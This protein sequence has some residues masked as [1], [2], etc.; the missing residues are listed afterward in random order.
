MALIFGTWLEFDLVRPHL[1][2]AT[3]VLRV[4][5]VALGGEADLVKLPKPL[6]NIP[7]PIRRFVLQIARRP[8]A[9]PARRGRPPPRAALEADRREAAPVRVP[10]PLP[11]H[12]A[13]VRRDPPHPRGR[14]LHRRGRRHGHARAR[15]PE[16]VRHPARGGARG[17]RTRARA[18]AGAAPPRASSSAASTTCCASARPSSPRSR[19]PRPPSPRPS[20]SPRWPSIR[21]RTR[22]LP[23][24]VFFPRGEVTNAYATDDTRPPIPQ[25]DIDAVVAAIQQELINRAAREEPLDTVELDEHLQGPDRPVPA[26]PRRPPAAHRPAREPVAAAGRGHAAPVPALDAAGRPA[27]GPRPERPALRRRLAHA[28]PVRLH[29]PALRGRRH[30]LRRPD[31]R[32]GAARRVR[33]RRPGPAGAPHGRNPAPGHG[34][35]LLQRRPVRRDDRRVRGLHGRTGRNTARSSTR[36]PSSSASTCRATPRSRSRRSS[37]STGTSCCG[38]T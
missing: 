3:D 30:A 13:G 7:R 18:R 25:A 6:P 11:E 2:T 5:F 26:A 19:T 14:R 17:R 37:T 31:V 36:A 28:R 32:T 21:A 34:R 22:P 33:V 8:S 9:G 12:G 1:K 20:C 38:R 4:L 27:R 16:N 23:K 35:L 29:R 15:A 24:R 10:G